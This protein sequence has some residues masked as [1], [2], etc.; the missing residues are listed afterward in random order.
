MIPKQKKRN[1]NDGT[2]RKKRKRYQL[3]REKKTNRKKNDSYKLRKKNPD[4]LLFVIKGNKVI[5]FTQII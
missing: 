2:T 1:L 4:V 5:I 3:K